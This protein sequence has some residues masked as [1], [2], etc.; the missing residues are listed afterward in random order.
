[1]VYLIFAAQNFKSLSLYE[2]MVQHVCVKG[3][4]SEHA[5]SNSNLSYPPAIGLYCI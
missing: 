4:M 1:M 5:S 3:A 2:V